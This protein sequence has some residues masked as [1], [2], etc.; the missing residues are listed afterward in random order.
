MINR[1]KSLDVLRGLTVILMTVGH[2]YYFWTRGFNNIYGK[3]IFFIVVIGTPFFPI[4][5]GFSYYIYINKKIKDSFS[6]VEIFKEVIKRATLIYLISVLVLVM[7]GFTLSLKFTSFVYW[8][9]FQIIAFSMVIF[10][11]IPFLKQNIRRIL[12]LCLFFFIFLIAHIII[13]NK[14]EFLYVFVLQGSFPFLPWGNFFLFGVICS[15]LILNSSENQ[16]SIILEFFSLIGIT[17]ITCYFLWFVNFDYLYLSIFFK[18]LGIFLLSFSILY[19][20]LDIKDYNFFFQRRLSEWGVMAFS[21]YYI[22]FAIIVVG[23]MIFPLII[24][25]FT[26]HLFSIHEYLLVITLSIVFIDIFLRI[27]KKFN[28]F[29]GIEWIINKFSPKS[30]FSKEIQKQNS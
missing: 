25:D 30:Q 6:R 27:W 9:I 20:L 28:Y 13:V 10:F 19:L 15:D 22:Q 11:I 5:A 4:M 17:L 3:I 29:L 12:C 2:M 23:L 16:I 7:F 18:N 21:L 8:N 14:I 26:S 24:T 1:I